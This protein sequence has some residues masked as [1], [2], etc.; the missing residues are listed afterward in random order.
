MVCITPCSD[1]ASLH[2]E[3]D[4]G[5]RTNISIQ[6]ELRQRMDAAPQN[7]SAVA[8]EAFKRAIEWQSIRPDLPAIMATLVP[9]M[10]DAELS[11]TLHL[12]ANRLTN[13]TAPHAPRRRRVLN[14]LARGM[15]PTKRPDEA[16][17]ELVLQADDDHDNF[18]AEIEAEGD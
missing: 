6:A 1:A 3:E 8:A 2:T 16:E 9:V 7:W 12:I 5:D 11:E 4:H 13:A 18:L 14:R 17:M 15:V 10:T